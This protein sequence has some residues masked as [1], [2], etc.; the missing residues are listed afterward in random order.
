MEPTWHCGSPISV[1]TPMIAKSRKESNRNP[2][3][4]YLCLVDES[5][6]I[7]IE[8]WLSRGGF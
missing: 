7:W 2:T 8:M 4:L 3:E 6:N 1:N 5:E